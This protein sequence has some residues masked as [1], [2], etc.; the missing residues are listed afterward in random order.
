[1]QNDYPRAITWLSDAEQH[2]IAGGYRSDIAR[3]WLEQAWVALRQERLEEALV[4]YQRAEKAYMRLDMPIRL[5]FCAKNAG[6]LFARLGAYDDALRS[7]LFALEHFNALGH[8][9]DIG[10]CQ[11]NLGNIYFYTGLWEAALACYARAEQLF[12]AGGVV[13]ESLVVRRNRALVY[14]IQ[15]RYAEARSLLADI[16]AQAQEIGNQAELAEVWMQQAELLAVGDRGEAPLHRYQEARALFAR[17]GHALDAAECDVNMGWLTLLRGEVDRA[18]AHFRSAAPVVGPHPYYRWRTD[19]GLARC[20]EARGD[21]ATAL[22][23]YRAALATVAGLRRRLA[24]EEASSG[25]Y[26]QAVQLHA[27]ALRLAA[28]RGDAAAAITIAEQQRALV[29]RRLIADRAAELPAE[30]RAEHDRLRAAIEALLAGTREQRERNRSALDAALAAYGELLLHARHSAPGYRPAPAEP[31]FDLDL[32]RQA[33]HEAYGDEWSV[34]SYIP[35]GDTLLIGV[36][37]PGGVELERAPYDARLRQLIERASRPE[38]RLHTYRDLP[39]RMGQADRPWAGL[40]ALARRLLPA[41][42]RARLHPRHRLLIV[43]AGPLHGLP[44]AALRLGDA[45]LAERAIVQLAPSLAAWQTLARRT[46]PA[47]GAALLVACGAFGGRAPN[48]PAVA[49]EVALVASRWPGAV[50]QLLHEQATRAALL[51]RAAG[52]ELE[53]YSLLHFATHAQLLPSRGLAAHL[54]LWDG[55]LLL[56]EVASLRLGGGLV[57]L[58]ACDGAAADV[59]PG[60]EVLSLSWAFLAA[61]ASGVLASLWPVEDE[62]SIHFMAALYD[63]LRQHSDSAVALAHAQRALAAAPGNGDP[64]AEPQCWGSFVLTGIGRP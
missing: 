46:A 32:A 2:F 25:L 9:V 1:M 52:R 37:T 47:G 28:E 55:D 64:A 5:A 14:S 26:A 50:A 27:D 45:W 13:G 8:T 61:G 6:L 48:L 60:E 21:A 36:V 15:G 12:A 54:K 38:Y 19:Y 49:D 17:I 63:E 10:G 29:L 40:S 30:Y 4:G 33:L 11:L 3:C 35:H 7:S 56:P 16:Q 41:S 62:A 20:A 58:S 31:P 34:V 53:R 51:E 57:V 22:E 18:W 42:L 24:N 23:R 44:W 43:P 59:L 39:Y